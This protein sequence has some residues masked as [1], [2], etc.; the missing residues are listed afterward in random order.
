MRGLL[1]LLPLLGGCELI[2]LYRDEFQCDEGTHAVGEDCEA[3]VPPTVIPGEDDT[4]ED[5]TGSDDTGSDDTASGDDSGAAD[6]TASG[7]DS[8]AADDSTADSG[9]DD[10]SA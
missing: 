5:D 2:S 9:A 10:T 6:D 3:D 4:G 8:G 7:D 1:L